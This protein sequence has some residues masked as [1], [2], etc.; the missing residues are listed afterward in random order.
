M[1]NLDIITIKIKYL[2]NIT[3]APIKIN[4]ILINSKIKKLNTS[5]TNDF[6]EKVIV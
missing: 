3:I 1:V 5:K 4:N 6:L 2:T